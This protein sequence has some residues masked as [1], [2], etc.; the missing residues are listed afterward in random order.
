[1]LTTVQEKW[2]N[3]RY[4]VIRHLGVGGMARVTL[5]ADRLK[6]GAL[7][8][9]KAVTTAKKKSFSQYESLFRREFS[10]LKRLRHPNLVKVYDFSRDQA[11]GTYFFVMDYVEG[12]TLEQYGSGRKLS[13]SDVLLIMVPLL[14]VLAFIH[15]RGLVYGDVKPPNIIR[16]GKHTMD[17]SIKLLDFG[18]SDTPDDNP[19]PEV[20]GTIRYMAPEVIDGR[21]TFQSDIF[22]AGM[23]FCEL[24][25]G[26]PFYKKKNASSVFLT[27]QSIENYTCR[28]D[29]VLAAIEDIRL[30]LIVERMIAYHTGER[31]QDC[32]QVL[33]DLRNALGLAYPIESA[34]S[35]VAYANDWTMTGRA[36]E[37]QELIEFRPQ[38]ACSMA[39]V[40]GP[41]G[42]GKSMLL[43]EARKFY[44]LHD[45]PCLFS[46][47]SP[48]VP[49]GSIKPLLLECL[50]AADAD[51]IVRY[52][53]VLKKLLPQNDLLSGCG[54]LRISG[55][56]KVL[57][58]IVIEAVSA[59]MLSIIQAKA[60][61]VALCLDDLDKSDDLSLQVIERLLFKASRSKASVFIT[62][63]VRSEDGSAAGLLRK[64]D[65]SG[66]L[67]RIVLHSFSRTTLYQY[68]DALFGRGAVADSVRSLFARSLAGLDGNPFHIQQLLRALLSQQK[69]VRARAQWE[70]RASVTIQDIP[71][72]LSEA[73]AISF[74]VNRLKGM[75]KQVLLIFAL[76]EQPVHV[77]L[78][79]RFLTE[80]GPW[81]KEQTQI[82]LSGLLVELIDQNVV[83]FENGCFRLQNTLLGL[84]LQ[85]RAG[86]NACRDARLAIARVCGEKYTQ[87]REGEENKADML[88][89]AAHQYLAA[90]IDGKTPRYREILEILE[91]AGDYALEQHDLQL[92]GT[93]YQE[94]TRL[95]TPMWQQDSELG[96]GAYR[97]AMKYGSLLR[98][99]GK[100]RQ[101]LVLFLGAVCMASAWSQPVVLET[102]QRAVALLFTNGNNKL[103]RYWFYKLH[104]WALRRRSEKALAIISYS[105]GEYHQ[106]VNAFDAALRYYEQSR[107]MW[108]KTGDKQQIIDACS[109]MGSIY[110]FSGDTAKGLTEFRKELRFAH[111]IRDVTR[112]AHA[113]GK[114]GSCFMF[115]KE[116]ARAKVC[117]EKKLELDRLQ[118]NAYEESIGLSHLGL[119]YYHLKDNTAAMS[120]LTAALKLKED[121]G[122]KRGLVSV[123]GNIAVVCIGEEDYKQALVYL[124]RSLSIA[125]EL[126]DYMRKALSLY[127]IGGIYW[128]TGMLDKGDD[129]FKQAIALAR[130]IQAD[131]YV[132][133]F[134]CIRTKQ[135]LEVT[136][137]DEAGRQANAVYTLAVSHDEDW[138][139]RQ[140]FDL[141]EVC[142]EYARGDS[143]FQESLLSDLW[144]GVARTGDLS[145]KFWI[146]YSV[147]KLCVEEEIDQ[148]RDARWWQRE[149]LALYDMLRAR[150][151]VTKE[152]QKMAQAVRA[153]VIPGP[154]N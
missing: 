143:A 18:I 148:G 38:H 101:A 125:E 50:L 40:S 75:H 83:T 2:I 122:E 152:Q 117:L 35:A 3:N 100:W 12:Q 154:S 62:A 115:R 71:A 67:R 121:M 41:T 24:L 126:H 111:A 110:Q 30:R 23:V 85:R 98:R 141:Y 37:L 128:Q 116:Y 47:C 104:A 34:R 29:V 16:T 55:S 59:F 39:L 32:W 106:S 137:F 88:L 124:Y 86:S 66:R 74:A 72:S 15:A 13:V 33:D 64:L 149:A 48:A 57:K 7:F 5:V 147:C 21:R 56:Q 102:Y 153:L 44:Q 131:Y 52:G 140:V 105:L 134:Q 113:L 150:G 14:R 26:M 107:S 87:A 11:D 129:Y 73:I 119:L 58:D 65:T 51:S 4:R 68:L 146:C 36:Q 112:T 93:Y 103:S 22:A 97:I 135:L 17:E 136:R 25:A 114:L 109:A 108:E 90:G 28:R 1:M 61:P 42:F 123:L 43:G 54:D 145:R 6:G 45:I 144:Q 84:I 92:A 138:Q 96:R 60:R 133:E 31:Y 70:L 69:L 127:N 10:T 120:H 19:A 78:L 79:A 63:A 151:P 20:R 99:S 9:L 46:E 81:D 77:D 130:S 27:L 82:A 8:A 118:G 132:F 76:F 53:P 80:T 95:I 49:Y 91:A 89:A 94:L 142:L 139:L